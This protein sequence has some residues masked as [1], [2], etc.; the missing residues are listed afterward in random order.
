MSAPPIVIV[1]AG[2]GG[3]T[4]ALCLARAGRRV[5]VLERAAIIE[6]IGAGLQISPNAGRILASLGLEAELAAVG[7]EPQA[8]NIRRMESG[9]IL[10]RLPLAKARECW[11]APFRVFHRADLQQTL[12][13]EAQNSKLIDIR[14]AARVGD[15]DEG[16]PGVVL[17]VHGAQGKIDVEASGLVGADGVRSSVRGR[18]IR[19]FKDAPRYTG[20]TAWRAL[21]S[22]EAAPPSLRNPE[23]HLWLGPGA[24]VVH[25]PLRDASIIS[26][27]VIVQDKSLRDRTSA[28][29]TIDGA[30]LVQSLA[31]RRINEDLRSVIE[32]GDSWRYWPL[33]ARPPLSRWSKG[34][35]TLLGD[36]AHPMLPFLAQGAAQA[37]ED[38]D[39]LGRAFMTHGVSIQSAFD[40]YQR[41]RMG[42][43]NEIQRRSMG[44]GA[45]V[46]M[47]GAAAVFRDFTIKMLGGRGMLARNAWIYR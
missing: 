32:A 25:Y 10:A 27:V 24:H 33:F 14:T 31:L 29:L 11:G 34:P 2:V 40:A 30:E 7:L 28:P 21:I 5:T 47:S 17:R 4:A 6:E 23:T 35:V 42:R 9:Y 16:G 19:T 22:A 36:A 38:A 15:F 20:Y 41:E 18:L 8:I 44:Q 3:L 37:I 39:A 1:G 26:V 12:L 43:A 46:H 45:Y 13:R